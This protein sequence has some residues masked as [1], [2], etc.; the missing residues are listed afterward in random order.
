MEVDH[1]EEGV[2]WSVRVDFMGRYTGPALEDFHTCSPV[3][4]LTFFIIFEQGALDF[5]FVLSPAKYV[6]GPVVNA[7]PWYLTAGIQRKRQI[8]E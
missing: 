2:I 5:Y 4:I 8:L 7:K 3:I 1:L 6:A